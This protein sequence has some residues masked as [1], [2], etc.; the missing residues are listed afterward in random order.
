MFTHFYQIL[1]ILT[2][3]YPFLPNFTQF[4][5]CVQQNLV[6]TYQLFQA[7]NELLIIFLC[8]PFKLELATAI[9]DIDLLRTERNIKK[10]SELSNHI[11]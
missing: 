11:L 2:K 10:Q 1:P 6:L 8:I 7:C 9:D 4:Y 3:F 5:P